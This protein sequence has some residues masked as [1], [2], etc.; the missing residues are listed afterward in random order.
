VSGGFVL[1]TSY[2]TRVVIDTD[3]IA[4]P[5]ASELE[6]CV[7]D[8]NFFEQP[9]RAP[10]PSG[11]ADYRSYSIRIEDGTK[12]HAIEFTDLTRDED[13]LRLLLCIERIA[14][15]STI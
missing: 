8:A 2:A 6:S 10:A 3:S 13:L 1:A 4:L 15:S 7:R 14:R 11:A 12:I 9:A 5:L